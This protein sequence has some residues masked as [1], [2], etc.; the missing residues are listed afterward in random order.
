MAWPLFTVAA[1]L[2]AGKK[3]GGKSLMFLPGGD[4]PPE[5]SR[6][7]I[8]STADSFAKTTTLSLKATA[9]YS[10]G[11]N[12][13]ITTEASWSSSDANIIEFV[14]K[15]N[16]KGKAV[17]VAKV[18]IEFQGKTAQFTL[19][20]TPA[21][22]IGTNLTCAE[23]GNLPKG[24]TRQCTL[25]GNFADG[26]NQN[27]T[28]DP[29]A[30]W[31]TLDSSKATVDS[32]GLVTAVD[33]GSTQIRA[34]Y[35]GFTALLPITV[36]TATLVSLAVTPTNKSLPLGKKQQYTATGTYSD[37]SN[38][39]ITGSV[40][41]STGN[42][43][44]ATISTSGFLSTQSEGGTEVIATLGTVSNQ[45]N[46]T[47][48]PAVLET[49]TI[50]PAAPSIAKGRIENMIATGNMSDGTTTPIT[51]Q[52]TW[53][54]GDDLVV[55]VANGAGLHGRAT[56]KKVGST[57]VQAEIGGI[58]ASV[59]FTVTAAVIDSIEVHADDSSIP[60][61]T[62]TLVTATAIFSDGT[63]QNVSDQVSWN[64]SSSSILQLG[65][66]TAGPKKRV[67]SPNN[68]S[69]GTARITATLGAN[70]GF[71]D[72][73]VAA[74]ILVSIQVDPTNPSVAKGLTKTFS[75]TGTYSDTSTQT[76][77]TL[78]TWNS[79]NQSVAEISNA[80]GSEGI[81]TT[82]IVGATNITATL[83]SVTSPISVLTVTTEEL[84]DITIAPSPTLSIAKGRNQNF[85]ATGHYTD[86]STPTITDQVTWSSTDTTNAQISNDPGT[87]GK[88]TALVLGTAQIK[89]KLGSVESPSTLVTVTAAELDSIQVTPI[90]A[91]VAKGLTKPY[92][93]MGTYSDNNTL[94][95]T[96][97]VTWD[98]SSTATA[99]ISNADPTRG[100]ASSKA[101]GTTTISA[102]LGTVTGSTQ[103]QVTAKE[104]VS[105]AVS[106]TNPSIF[107]SQTQDFSATG[108]Y[109]DSTT[110]DLTTQV[111]WSPSSNG[112]ATISNAPG[113]QGRATG[114]IAGTST[115]TA[116]FG[117]ITG[118]TVLTVATLDTTA[119]TVTNVVSLTP[120][121]I[122]VTFSEP[123]NSTQATTASNYKVVLTS[124]MT[125]TCSNNSNFSSSSAISVSS[126][127]GTGSVYTLTLGSSQN[128]GTNYTL[129]VNKIGIQ[130]LAPSPN[131][132]GCP[133]NADFVGLEQLKVSSASCS[134]TSQVIVNFSKPVKVG[135]NV[136]GSAECT[137]AI[138]CAKRFKL[139][140]TSNLGD[141]T[142]ARILD[143][144]VCGGA[145]ADTS[146]V[147]LSHS[148]LQSG[149]QYQVTVANGLDGDGFDNST[150]G[151]LRDSA[152]SENVQSSP[153]DRA[154][155]LGCGSSPVNFN[156]GPISTDPFADNSSFGYLTDYNG[157]IYIGPNV[158]G[159]AATRFQYDGSSPESI[160]FTF[161]K[162][163]DNS[164]SG[165]SGNT[166]TTR[167]GSITVPPYVT[168]GHSGC[169]QN[170][171]NLSTGCG[172]D[173]EDGR[174]VFATGMLGSTPNIF[175][176]AARSGQN[177]DYLYYSSD[178]DSSLDFKYIDLGTITGTVTAGTSSIG[179]LNNR[180]FVGFAKENTG[181]SNAP[182]FGFVTFNSA[183]SGTGNCTIGTS[184]DANDG[185]K[186][187][188]VRIDFLSFFGG[189]SAG[190]DNT[191][192][193]WGYYIGVDSIFVFR[194]FI[195]AAN[196]G[197]H[198][199]DHNGSII[200]STGA[201]PTTACSAI[202]TC[203]NWTEVG[204]RTNAK[205]Y[206]SSP[207]TSNRYSLELT[208]FFD[209]IPGD[210][211]FSM[212]AQY[213]GNLYVTRTTCQVTQ[214]TATTFRTGIT[215]IAGCTDGTD[216]N[217]RA[218][219]WK[220]V[221]ET[222]GGTDT[223]D[224]GDWSVVGDDGTGNTNFGEDTNRTITM[225][226]KNGAYLYVGFDNPTTGIQ[227]WR[228][229]DTNPGSSSS[230]WT[231]IGGNGLGDATNI[232]QI[233]SATSVP[234]GG[235]NY[236]YVSAG[237]NGVPVRVYRQ[238]N[239]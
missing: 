64:T 27:L 228:T 149:A 137:S 98:S 24:I 10:D 52:V 46:V 58:S 128:S 31:D 173:N 202:N 172:P 205:W 78:V 85:T 191:S 84:L 156:D 25:T 218:Q 147:C 159:N 217:R 55:D 13:D 210:K 233:F 178:I 99:E 219:L 68:G 158:L 102:Q 167:D 235:V 33:A 111:T 129:V 160:Q 32:N 54:S 105:I 135:N 182:D 192:P 188:R 239:E 225:V 213:N 229:G 230:S 1:G 177:F 66:L 179:V 17:G 83:G 154:T 7:E 22:L 65:V 116:T 121:T 3:G 5:L 35:H 195:Y 164:N 216:T 127:S 190:T 108:T 120:T 112:V 223:C 221:P 90:N 34:K 115:I 50:T 16:A 131:S 47:V 204:P 60:K 152:D 126:V 23:T 176:A 212:F 28:T 203:T 232:K 87:K 237:K 144:T 122:K 215:T 38:V 69:T 19:T 206:N 170:N 157:K 196:G 187:R 67:N 104:L 186:G 238:Q 11:T 139:S 124:G 146:K 169:T 185:T 214:S 184:C 125:G 80:G 174:G 14:S 88:L 89:A 62:N 72:I 95:I 21:P 141:I 53:S 30:Q 123:V 199:L 79:S 231:K 61:G 181:E 130:D 113:T 43:G 110:N 118:S 208:K 165:T 180:V 6:I 224:A 75:A 163:T 94:D 148:L 8:S 44:I 26:T 155:F 183:D 166:A 136:D 201:D 93:A 96:T 48:T 57:S 42:G 193:N 86:G 101:V 197:H 12:Q 134:S 162:D 132:L 74:P 49:I 59:T 82:K 15:A 73:I 18:K 200:R 236:L 4:N 107:T 222:S 143:G 168:L 194:N 45:T 142:Q 175:I 140:G 76:L 9:I 234:V 63:N 226:V 41:W 29:A 150:F 51:D 209:L 171:A 117:S 36:S 189:G 114:V 198:K 2:A 81:A 103:L 220:C 106:P 91:S 70:S 92:T 109:T 40:T 145:A 161:A 20:V 37:N 138:Q 211:A 71:A 56:A 153:R 151:S 207:G 97:Q 39:D 100:V 119:P 77:T 133:N 227:V